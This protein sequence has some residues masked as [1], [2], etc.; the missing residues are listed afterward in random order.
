MHLWLED[1]VDSSARTFGL[2]DISL[3]MLGEDLKASW[4]DED[5]FGTGISLR[6][7]E[8]GAL[9]TTTLLPTILKLNSFPPRIPAVTW[10]LHCM[11]N[12]LKA[13]GQLLIPR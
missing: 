2:R 10:P 3:S 11:L 13:V 8:A 6:V 5:A 1:E 4:V 9:S 7:F 12:T